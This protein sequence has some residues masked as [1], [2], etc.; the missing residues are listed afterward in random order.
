MATSATFGASPRPK[1]AR[2]RLV[3]VTRALIGL[4]TVS[5]VVAVIVQA[6]LPPSVQ[7]VSPSCPNGAVDGTDP[8]GSLAQC[9]A[10]SSRHPDGDIVNTS[11]PTVATIG[12]A[13]AVVVGTGNGSL[14]A[15][16]LSSG[17]SDPGWPVRTLA[18]AYG[19]SLEAPKA[20]G[21][22]VTCKESTNIA[23][24]PTLG[25]SGP[26]SAAVQSG[27]NSTIYAQL[28]G[29]ND[30]PL[31]AANLD[32]EPDYWAFDASGVALWDTNSNEEGYAA[33]RGEDACNAQN[34]PNGSVPALGGMTISGTGPTSLAFAT[35]TTGP[36]IY[37]LNDASGAVTPGWPF[38]NTDSQL[39]TP[40]VA[41]PNGFTSPEVAFTSD[42]TYNPLD[43]GSF[44]GGHYRELA[45]SGNG[46]NETGQEICNN[47]S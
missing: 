36:N 10:W 2:V 29:G 15:L 17:V 32:R 45:T 42:Q 28:G 8:G 18:A 38:S 34:E 26:I 6:S 20:P 7:A 13:P 21:D 44:G 41:Q 47:R 5:S 11:S 37:G 30:F 35:S 25:V 1:R 33:T 27:K 40:L 9:L 24:Y 14:E 43:P 16:R 31:T 39:T 19:T 22:P 46:N 23:G 12:G 3:W 4:L